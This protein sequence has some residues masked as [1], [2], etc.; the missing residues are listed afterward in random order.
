M[1]NYQASLAGKDIGRHS[2]RDVFCADF[3]NQIDEGW[4]GETQVRCKKRSP[5][6]NSESK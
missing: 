3:I 1:I 6:K 5:L 2:F 4:W